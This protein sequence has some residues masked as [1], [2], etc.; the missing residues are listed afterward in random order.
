MLRSMTGYG[1]AE[2]HTEDYTVKVEIRSLNGKF[3]DLSLRMP[4]FLMPKE[5]EIRNFFGKQ[6][7]RGSATVTINVVK[8]KVNEN[9]IQIN[10]ALATQ[11]YKKLKKLS[12]SLDAP[13]HDIF[14]IVTTMQ[15]VIY[16]DDEQSEE[17]LFDLVREVGKT[18]F[19][20]YDAF[21]L[22]EGN[23]VREHLT[24][25]SNS[26]AACIAPIEALEPERTENTKD[27]L[28]KN[29]K[30][31]VDDDNFDKNRFEQ[32]LIYYLEKYDIQEEKSRLSAHC[33]HF[34]DALITNPKGKSLNFI[35]QE[36]GREINTLGS[37][38]NHAGIQKLVI[39]MKEELEKIK[40]QT[41]NIL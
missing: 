9:D 34:I 25:Y 12:E 39:A 10:D 40:E 35:A 37:K 15:D 22:R 11:Y 27:R 18:A 33:V 2:K 17:A 23:E 31:V 13:Q 26:I 16:Q 19:D 24:Q 1:V 41:L 8:H 6:I 5:I 20:E 14:R 32:E 3:L 38:A 4:R 29:L 36:M 7:E 28:K 30:Q 21:R